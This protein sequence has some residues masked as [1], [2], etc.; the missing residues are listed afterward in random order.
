[1]A[2]GYHH[3]D[4]RATLLR[5][6]AEVLAAHGPDGVSLRALARQAG[7]SHAA[8][9]HHF[10][11][12]RGLIT[13]LVA[14]GHHLLA[15]A[16]GEAA[17]HGS[18]ADVGLAYVRFALEHPA[19]FSVMFSPSLVD[20]DD[21]DLVEAKERT[22][23]MLRGGSRDVVS[24]DPGAAAVAAWSMVHGLATLHLAGSLATGAVRD[25]VADDSGAR[26]DV[27]ALARRALRM[28]FLPGG[29]DA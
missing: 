25:V 15:D 23:A 22:L 24:D 26:D 29:P 20:E 21:A 7:V 19:H 1:M 17:R 14:Q 3:G 11:S 10:G 27:L 8:P 6:T 16:M 9:A 2:D 4:L 12:R 5:R 13:A 28:L 18:F